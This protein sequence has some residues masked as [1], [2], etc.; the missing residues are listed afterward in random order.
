[1]ELGKQMEVTGTPTIFIGGRKIYNLGQM[2][3]E[4]LKRVADFMVTGK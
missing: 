3:P 2:T 4:Q 1:M